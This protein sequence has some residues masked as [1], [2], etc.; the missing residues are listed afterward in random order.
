MPDNYSQWEAHQRKQD[1]WLAERPVCADCCE[2][3]QDG[4]AYHK[5]GVWICQDCMSA[6]L[7]D[8]DDYIEGDVEF[9]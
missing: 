5:D 8:V 1:A 4:S 7:V 6:Y 9:L 3:I 2:H